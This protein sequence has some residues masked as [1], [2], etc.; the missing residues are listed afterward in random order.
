MNAWTICSRFS[1]GSTSSGDTDIQYIK[2]SELFPKRSP[3][4]EGDSSS[5]TTPPFPQLPGEFITYEVGFQ[6]YSQVP[7]V[8]VNI[9]GAPDGSAKPKSSP[10]LFGAAY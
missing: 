10:V 3:W 7:Y 5:V 8:A 4:I 6:L 9:S 1:V 2:A